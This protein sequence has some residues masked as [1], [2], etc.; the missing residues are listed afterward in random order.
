MEI[1]PPAPALDRYR[2]H[3]DK[4]HAQKCKD[5]GAVGS[6][7]HAT[8]SLHRNGP[9][10]HRCQRMQGKKEQSIKE[11]VP[12]QA[13]FEKPGRQEEQHKET[14]ARPQRLGWPYHK[15][16]VR[17]MQAEVIDHNSTRLLCP[18]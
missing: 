16:A 13:H 2:S 17:A 6:P 7:R 4:K 11:P 3:V 10:D 5:S 14:N 9:T 8:P 18:P 15:H 1:S 12:R